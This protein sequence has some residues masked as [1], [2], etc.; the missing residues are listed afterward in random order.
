MEH[1]QLAVQDQVLFHGG[2][3]FRK[4]RQGTGQDAPAGLD[5]HQVAAGTAA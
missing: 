1:D 4:I 5:P 3:S 2:R